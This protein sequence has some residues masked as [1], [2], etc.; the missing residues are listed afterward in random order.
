MLKHL[1]IRNY[2]LIKSLDL[3]FS[4]GLTT[5]TGETGAGKSILLGAIGLILGQR[6]DSS[7]ISVGETKCV[8]EASFEIES[9]GL[10]STF[11]NMGIDYDPLCILRREIHNSGKSRAFINDTPVNLTDLKLIGSLLVEIQ[12]QHANLMV[13]QTVEQ[14]KL[15]D[16]H[17]N[18]S[19]V[20]E[21]YKL[22]FS[23]YRQL[24]SEHRIL[25]LKRAELIKNRDYNEFLLTELKQLQINLESD[26][27]IE[28][29]IDLL[30]Q[31][32]KIK[33][34]F[35]YCVGLLENEQMGLIQGINSIRNQLKNF[36]DINHETSSLFDRVESIGIELKELNSDLWDYSEKYEENPERLEW[37]N[38]RHSKIQNLLKKHQVT[39]IEE[40][41][42]IENK[43]SLELLD[44]S[45]IDSK[46]DQFKREQDESKNKCIEFAK[47]IT[48][49]RI[50][51][52]KIIQEQAVLILSNLGLSH[53]QLEFDITSNY[54]ELSETGCDEVLLK[55]SANLGSTM[56]PVGQVA[57]GGEISRLN[58]AI[59][60]II[61]KKKNLPTLIY[62]E[63]DTGI[64]GEIAGKMGRIFKDLGNHHQV[65]CITHLPQVAS[66]G[67]QQLFV[68]K[69]V[70]DG[71]TVTDVS[72]LKS[73]ERVES[74]ASMLSGDSITDSA[75]NTARELLGM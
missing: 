9:L 3:D 28:Q 75:R 22:E 24:I 48:S 31:V 59:R 42:E 56:M 30:S 68:K 10:H 65:I 51:S 62:D 37:L 45:E 69:G 32:E 72:Y 73:D 61:A 40:L 5:V 44:V 7:E 47:I 49:K 27:N 71:K 25:E 57:S 66:C 18:D 11:Q 14:R 8:I 19:P 39:S 2:A 46:L 21:N 38:Q 1:H 6:A 54:N 12:T 63:A 36:K 60:S 50:E 58:F 35:N 15:L 64:S 70:L 43:L 33:S 41:N 74:I 26:K 13:T 29:E 20:F 34:A 55:F 67:N 23:R 17:F 52:A 53:A 16:F 4:D